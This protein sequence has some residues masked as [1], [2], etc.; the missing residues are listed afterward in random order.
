M[1]DN[2]QKHLD[3]LLKIH[4]GQNINSW[5]PIWH[6]EMMSARI[7]ACSEVIW[8]FGDKRIRS[9]SNCRLNHIS[10]ISQHILF[11]HTFEVIFIL[12]FFPT[13]FFHSKNTKIHENSSKSTIFHPKSS[14]P[15]SCHGGRR[16][17]RRN[18][19]R[20]HRRRRRDA[21]DLRAQRGGGG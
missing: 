17:P 5:C 14:L 19:R 4:P 21:H 7:I 13:C 3:S 1:V 20:S 18:R 6:E 12:H 10:N 8:L 16:R 2:S 11:Y 9:T 15:T